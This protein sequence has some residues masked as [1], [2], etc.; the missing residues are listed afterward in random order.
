[1]ILPLLLLLSQSLQRL[2]KI[3]QTLLS[4]HRAL[5]NVL[6]VLLDILHLR[7]LLAAARL[8]AIPKA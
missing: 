2:Q 1:M 4:V 5:H 6:P 7:L 3:Y 8:R